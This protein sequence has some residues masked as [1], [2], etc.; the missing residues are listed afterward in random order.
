LFQEKQIDTTQ[1]VNDSMM[2][3]IH[4]DINLPRFQRI[5]ILA[6][7]FYFVKGNYSQVF[8]KRFVDLNR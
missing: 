5:T 8:V 2:S 7:M 1:I 4:C 6:H 3:K